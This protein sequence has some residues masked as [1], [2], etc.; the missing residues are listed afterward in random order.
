MQ[1][2]MASAAAVPMPGARSTPSRSLPELSASDKAAALRLW[3]VSANLVIVALLSVLV[4]VSVL[5]NRSIYVERA[6]EHTSNIAATLSEGFRADID[7]IDLAL[8]TV[9]SAHLRTSSRTPFDSEPM[10]AIMADMQSALPEIGGLRITD[11]SGN[12]R[13]GTGLEPAQ[14]MSVGDRSYFA[15]ARTSDSARP[16]VSEPVL[17][18][19]SKTWVVVVARPLRNPDGSF[20]GIVYANLSSDYFAAK[21]ARV[22]VGS[23]GAISLRSEAMSLIARRSQQGIATT[24]IGDAT[25]SDQLRAAIATNPR[26]GTYVAETA[27]DQVE[28]A[29]TYERVGDHPLYVIVGLGTSE[30]LQP[31]RTQSAQAAVLVF[32][33]ICVLGGASWIVYTASIRQVKA[34]ELM[35]RAAERNHALLMTSV[36]GI[37]VLDRSGRLVE[38][39]DAFVAMLGQDR[40]TLQGTHITHWDAVYAPEQLSVWLR[41][42]RIGK[43]RRSTT[44]FR[45]ADGSLIDVE[46]TSVAVRFDGDDLIYCSAR[47]MTEHHRLQD[48]IA[49][50]RLKAEENERQLRAI[51]DNAPALISYLDR[52]QRFRFANAGY[53]DWLGVAPESL[54]GRS[55]EEVYGEDDHRTFSPHIE[56]ALAGECVTYERV[57]KGLSG[58]RYVQV[59]IVPD[60]NS[61]GDVVGLHVLINDMTQQKQ[62][63]QALRQSEERL[64]VVTDALPMR[65]AYIDAEE[66][67]RF[68]NLAY[69]HAFGVPRGAFLGRT[70]H[71]VL[72]AEAYAEAEPFI[73]RALRGETTTF[74]SELVTDDTVRYYEA[75]YLPQT[76]E[77][78]STVLGFQA[79]VNDV[80]TTKLE[81]RRLRQLTQLDSLTGVA[82]R[83][84]LRERL[85]R[86]MQASMNS[87]ATIA[88]MYL[89]VDRFKHINDTYGHAVG[90]QL[91]KAFAGRLTHALRLSDTVARLGGDEFAIVLE[92]VTKAGDAATVAEKIL[93]AMR[94]P[95]VLG[96]L[97]LTITTSIG[98]ALYAGEPTTPETLLGEADQN[99]YRAKA[100]GRNAWRATPTSV[101]PTG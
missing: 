85:T 63:E 12:V 4:A 78:G 94:A 31:W 24:G 26:R 82:N 55:L 92:R 72:G 66:R 77:D 9:A 79:I 35:R 96:D 87:R 70:L 93:A 62:A 41:S 65:V 23:A 76:D 101:P 33:L 11:S 64:R 18:R 1:E 58:N 25:V 97:H 42:Y 49:Q 32:V 73:R 84:G 56:R 19:I 29:N 16:V 88:V 8:R 34:Q 69:E 90:D 74:M 67:F 91:L 100:A 54:Y 17:G 30:F 80:T 39:N 2:N 6:K 38:F 36:D 22:D 52:E 28:R 46:V 44:R 5:A 59:S 71:E 10:R 98:I 99:L 86:A 40:D 47:D 37:H 48:E 27:L 3:L 75:T 83:I 15:Q 45:R 13:L 21:F 81:E 43:A 14:H 95:F 7:R 57:L 51:T 89:D 53:R 60:R 50:G 61:D 20:A 68:N